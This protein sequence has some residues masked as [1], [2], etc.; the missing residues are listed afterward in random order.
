MKTLND[1]LSKLKFN[2]ESNPFHAHEEVLNL[3]AVR[4]WIAI[5]GN[6]SVFNEYAKFNCWCKFDNGV[7]CKYN[8][9][10]PMAIMTHFKCK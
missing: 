1:I 5:E 2:K 8:D 4:D 10:H 3:L 6:E 7:E 9:E